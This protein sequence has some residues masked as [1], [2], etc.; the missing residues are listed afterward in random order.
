MKIKLIVLLSFSL[1]LF[2]NVDLTAQRDNTKKPDYYKVSK[3]KIL[4]KDFS[5]IQKLRDQGIGREHI[6]VYEDYF[7]AFL[8]SFQ[9]D[10]LKKTGYQ[11][12]IIIEDVTK[13]YLER[14]KASRE[15]IKLNKSSKR[16]GFGYGSMGGYY[17]LD[18]L[19]AQLDTLRIL[20]PNLI[21]AKD[22]IGSTIE[23]RPIWAVKISDNPGN[24]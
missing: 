14:T 15:K 22:S 9:L 16:S 7:E 24:K 2:I 6:K 5:D 17:T 20:Y 12:E 19:I 3:V 8:D 13:D 21:T 23:G 4:I 10:G 18:E 11:Y 1:I